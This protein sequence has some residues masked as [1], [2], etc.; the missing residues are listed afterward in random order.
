MTAFDGGGDRR[1]DLDLGGG[2]RPTGVGI[3]VVLSFGGI[4]RQCQQLQSRTEN[5]TTAKACAATGRQQRL[6]K[7]Q[8]QEGRADANGQGMR[9]GVAADNHG[10]T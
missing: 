5:G 10:F 6:Q 2:M 3:I 4:Q 8:R 1:L 7:Q 9:A